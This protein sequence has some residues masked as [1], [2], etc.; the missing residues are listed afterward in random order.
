[1]R[2]H[3]CKCRDEPED[4][5]DRDECKNRLP[6]HRDAVK[7]PVEESPFRVRPIE[8]RD[9]LAEWTESIDP[10]RVSAVLERRYH[11]LTVEMVHGDQMEDASFWFPFERPHQQ[12][13]ILHWRSWMYQK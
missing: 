11:M 7:D 12:C 3:R 6:N 8:N 5:S 9:F 10:L 1:M 13:P 2:P 4:E